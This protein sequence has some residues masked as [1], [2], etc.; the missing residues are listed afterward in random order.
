MP[1]RDK[2][3]KC[4]PTDQLGSVLDWVQSSH[5]TILV[6][7]KKNF[8]GLCSP[9]QTLYQ[10]SYPYTSLVQHSLIH[11]P[12]IYDETEVYEVAEYMT[13]LRIYTLPIF[14]KNNKYKQTIS[15]KE[16]I[17]SVVKDKISLQQVAQNLEVE[18]IITDKQPSLGLI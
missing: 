14:T 6:F 9:Y 16:V 7:D 17:K 12:K 18:P 3:L 2:V 11:A 13:A 1:S 4:K 5:D 8:L 15:G 10:K